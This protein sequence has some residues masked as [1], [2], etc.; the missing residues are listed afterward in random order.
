MK[1]AEL[2]YNALLRAERRLEAAAPQTSS[3]P[4]L[5]ALSLLAVDVVQ[6]IR[7]EIGRGLAEARP[8]IVKAKIGEVG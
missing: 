6:T 5:M 3:N 8:A 1:D 7:E 2:I 4:A